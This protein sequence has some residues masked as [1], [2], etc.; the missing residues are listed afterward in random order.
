[1]PVRLGE[2]GLGSVG[3]GARANRGRNV[4]LR[5]DYAMVTN[6]GGTRDKGKGRLHFGAAYTF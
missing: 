6:Q 2:N 3:F 5:F 1:L 4:A